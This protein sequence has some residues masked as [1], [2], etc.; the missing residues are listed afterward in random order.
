MAHWLYN[1]PLWAL[2]L[3][4]TLAAIGL[5]IGGILL[6][7]RQ[8]WMLK[9]EDVSSVAAIHAFVGVL[10]AVLLGL[11]VVAV[12]SGYHDVERAVMLEA[13]ATG[14]L[15]R[16]LHGLE[17]PESLQAAVRDY[18]RQVIEIE[19]QQVREGKH[20]DRTWALIDKLAYDIIE[21]HPTTAHDQLLYPQLLS[22]MDSVLDARRERLFLG[23]QGISVITWVIISVGAVIT[24]GFACFFPIARLWTHLLMVGLMSALFGLMISLIVS[25][26]R[27]L[28]GQFSVEPD[29]FIKLSEN[30]NRLQDIKQDN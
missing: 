2:C 5:S 15:Y 4:L 20:D 27:P 1:Q 9:P 22:D 29:A 18:I 23:Q 3:A 21:L 6:V 16:N 8:R 12:Q 25:M 17:H 11:I 19:W 14:D 30:L 24:L 28:W 26:D 13:S 10:Y 7:R